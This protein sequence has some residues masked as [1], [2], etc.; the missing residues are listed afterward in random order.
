M[1]H[2]KFISPTCIKFQVIKRVHQMA[3]R[4]VHTMCVI[5]ED[6]VSIIE[7]WLFE[8]SICPD[9]CTEWNAL[10]KNL[11]ELW[12]YDVKKKEQK[13]PLRNKKKSSHK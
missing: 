4:P 5:R 7:I 8:M 13:C 10:E 3:V 2:S 6:T 1:H 12:Y 9:T 11:A